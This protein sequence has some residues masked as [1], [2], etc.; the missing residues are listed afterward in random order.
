MSPRKEE[1]TDR[2]AAQMLD[3]LH[4]TVTVDAT[5]PKRHSSLYTTK[6]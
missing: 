3:Y 2:R 6:R 4:G 1:V 5:H